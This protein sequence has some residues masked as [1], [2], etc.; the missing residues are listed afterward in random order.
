MDT[1]INTEIPF[2]AHC[3]Q[4]CTCLNG[5]SVETCE[6]CKRNYCYQCFDDYIFK[7]G[8]STQC[9]KCTLLAGKR[10]FSEKE[11]EEWLKPQKQGMWKRFEQEKLIQ[12]KCNKCQDYS[13]KNLFE[14]N[15]YCCHCVDVSIAKACCFCTRRGIK[16][17]AEHGCSR[18]KCYCLEKD[19]KKYCCKHSGIHQAYRCMDCRC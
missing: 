3:D 16:C 11:F 1:E 13:C 2:C 5:I 10:Y 4:K 15:G 17:H 7:Y 9:T 6:N 12:P 14:L 18:V 19:N 8:T